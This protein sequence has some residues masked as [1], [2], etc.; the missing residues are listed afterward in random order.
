MEWRRDNQQVGDAIRQ[1]E[2]VLVLVG[3]TRSDGGLYTCLAKNAVGSDLQSLQVV[4]SCKYF[5]LTFQT[6]TIPPDAI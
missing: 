5:R 4:V 6:K 1:S 2:A 3:V